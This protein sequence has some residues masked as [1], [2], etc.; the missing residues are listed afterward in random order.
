M[1]PSSPKSPASRLFPLPMPPAMPMIGFPANKLI[2]L[3]TDP[4]RSGNQRLLPHQDVVVLE[5]RHLGVLQGADRDVVFRHSPGVVAAGRRAH[6]PCAFVS[7]PEISG[8]R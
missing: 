8:Q 3:S 5:D 2:L 4:H 6:I 1:H 7:V